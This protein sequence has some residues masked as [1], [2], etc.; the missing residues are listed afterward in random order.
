[1]LTYRKGHWP[2]EPLRAFTTHDYTAPDGVSH[3]YTLAERNVRLRLPA[4]V[5]GRKTITL[6][7]VVRSSSNGHQTPILTSRTDLTAAEVAYRMGNRWRQE[8]F[9]KY[10]RTHFTLDALDS[11]A[12]GADDP[13]RSVPNPAKAAA[14]KKAAAA[15]RE[16]TAAQAAYG[17]AVITAAEHAKATGQPLQVDPTCNDAV[18]DAQAALTKAEKRAAKIPTRLPLAEVNPDAQLINE[19]TKLLTHAV[20]MATYN[21]ESALARLLHPH[22]PRADDE[23]RALLREAFTTSGDIHPAGGDLHIR[24]DP[25]SAPRHSR[26]LAALCAELTATETRYPG[27]KHKIIYTVKDSP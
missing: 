21:A 7:Q 16:L 22:Y 12:A 2:K 23:A 27:T 20:R 26:A 5:K 6:R 17:E 10:G 15:R 4:Q 25:L 9:F 11:Y 8:N 19:D 18:H 14:G 3:E 1:M 24:L 13:Q